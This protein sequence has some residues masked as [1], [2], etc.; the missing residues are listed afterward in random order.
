[1]SPSDRRTFLRGAAGA[2][3]AFAL[4]PELL[5]RPPRFAAPLA[6]GVIGTG[7]QGRAL[8]GELAKF[9]D[10]T[11]AALCDVDPSRLASAAR[12]APGAATYATHAQLLAEAT[13]DAVFVA[14]PTHLHVQPAR[15]ALDAGR[16]VFCEGPLASTLDD[17]RALALAARA[18]ERVFQ[19]GLQGRSDPIYGLA[20]SFVRSGAIRDVLSLR[21]QAHEKTSW[22]TPASDP[23]REAALNWKLDPALSLGLIGE[24]GTQQF[25]VVHWFTNDYP[26]S[27][28]ASGAVLAWPDGR[29]EPDTAAC[30]FVFPKGVRLAWDATLGNSFEGTFEQFVGTMGTVK[31]AWNA[32]WLFKEADAP[33]QG[34]EV[35]A[36]REKFHDDEGITLIADATKLAAQG[37]LKE[38]VGLP[39]PPLYYAVEA[40]LKSVAEGAPVVCTAEE[41]LR[42]TAVALAARRA[43]RE[44]V[45]VA[46][47]PA[48]LQVDGR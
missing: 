19:V 43:Q 14:T 20:R 23:A 29:D 44:G 28:R 5:A 37:K 40:F 47:D 26:V 34:W 13:L 4:Q 17:C 39:H 9:E 11:V 10:V 30:E 25:D 33:T 36:N 31:L 12:R 22:R 41:G 18:S 24:L 46:I 8:L 16:H 27:V 2:A 6:V 3:A 38:G 32:G 48:S 15:D 7:R 35:Y 21:A 45:E 1:M 42:A